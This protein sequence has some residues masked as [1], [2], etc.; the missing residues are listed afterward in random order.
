[1]YDMHHTIGAI[2]GVCVVA[3]GIAVPLYLFELTQPGHFANKYRPELPPSSMEWADLETRMAGAVFAQ[4][5]SE[6]DKAPTIEI[7]A[8]EIVAYAPRQ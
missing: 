3:A 5:K 2:L 1:M 6:I 7:P 8:T 4:P